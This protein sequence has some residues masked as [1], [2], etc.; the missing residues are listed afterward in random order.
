MAFRLTEG[1]N[2]EKVR[3]FKIIGRYGV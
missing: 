3:L 2:N 1:K